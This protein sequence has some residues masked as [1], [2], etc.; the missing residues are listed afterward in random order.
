MGETKGSEV[1]WGGGCCDLGRRPNTGC[2]LERYK[3]KL[4]HKNTKI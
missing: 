4:T 1:N 2:D 3:P